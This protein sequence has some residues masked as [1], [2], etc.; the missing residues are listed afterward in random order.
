MIVFG[1]QPF[2]LS[3]K[4]LCSQQLAILEPS[5]L[6]QT[7]LKTPFLL[8]G[9]EGYLLKS[10]CGR[11]LNIQQNSINKHLFRTRKGIECTYGIV[12]AKWCLLLKFIERDIATVD[13]IIKYIC[14]FHNT[15]IDMKRFER[16]LTDIT[17]K[18]SDHNKQ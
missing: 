18:F 12:S 14:V 17:E 16:H 8:M 4:M 1:K 11:E 9:V 10:F 2:V 13:N 7:I 5:C 6:L 3:Y 15:I